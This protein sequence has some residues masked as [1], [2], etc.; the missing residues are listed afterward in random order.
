MRGEGLGLNRAAH[1]SSKANGLSLICHE[2]ALSMWYAAKASP[3][4]QAGNCM[5]FIHEGRGVGVQQ[6]CTHLLTGKWAQPDLPQERPQYV[7]CSQASP[8][9]KM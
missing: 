8:V 2:N 3:A 5:Q 1:S 7:V 4:A 6:N 9:V